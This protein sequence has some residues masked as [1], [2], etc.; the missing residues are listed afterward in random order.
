[1]R[2]MILNLAIVMTVLFVGG[3]NANA[4][5]RIKIDPDA[6]FD[7]RV[8]SMMQKHDEKLAEKTAAYEERK[9]KALEGQT[10]KLG[11]V[12]AYAPDLYEMY[13]T[14]FGDHTSLHEALFSERVSIQNKTFN[15]AMDGLASLREALYPEVEAGTMTYKELYTAL[16]AYMNEQKILRQAQHIAYQEAI[17]ELKSENEFN[18]EA[19][20]VLKADLRTAISAED[21]DSANTLITELYDYLILHTQY[22]EAKLEVLLSIEY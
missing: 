6:R 16:K 4:E 15:K 10:M 19:V 1:M 22:D 12:E 8:E 20:K 3:I 17:S 9:A 21:Y 18:Q 2:K 14:A 11:L 5:E 13:V 7:A